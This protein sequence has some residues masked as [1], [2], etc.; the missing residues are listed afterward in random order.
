MAAVAMFGV[1]SGLA[2]AQDLERSQHIASSDVLSQISMFTYQERRTS[3][4]I[5]RATPVL[6]AGRGEAEV[7]YRDGNAEIAAEVSR[8]PPPASL[9]PFT[10]YVLWALTPDGRASN[11]GVLTGPD[12]GR[13]EVET[14]HPTSQF[15]LIVTAEPH[16][17]VSGAALCG[18]RTEH[19]GRHVQR[20][21]QNSRRGDEDLVVVRARGLRFVGAWRAQ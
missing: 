18:Q 2:S 16:F 8:M 11:Q 7:R 21:Q 9:G 6:S 17:A 20:S 1:F 14:Q 10:T 13:G 4:L 12:G 3:D 15:A 5:L 19:D